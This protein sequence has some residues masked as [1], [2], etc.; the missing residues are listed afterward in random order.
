MSKT[1]GLNVIFPDERTAE[2]LQQAKSILQHS[3]DTSDEEME[4]SD[5]SKD[6]DYANLEKP[7]RELKIV[8][9]AMVKQEF[10]KSKFSIRTSVCMSKFIKSIS[11]SPQLRTSHFKTRSTGFKQYFSFSD[12]LCFCNNVPAL[13][14]ALGIDY[15]V[16]DWRLFIDTGKKSLKAVLLSN[17]SKHNSIPIAYSKTMPEKYAEMKFLMEKIQYLNNCWKVCC[18]LKMLAILLGLQTGNTK[19]SCFFCLWD[20]N[21][22]CDHYDK[23]L[24]WPER[25]SHHIGDYNAENPPLIKKENVLLPPLHLK[26]GYMTCF[27]KKLDSNLGEL[28]LLYMFNKHC[29]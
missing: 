16:K 20:R 19:F 4:V 6:P 25:N 7:V 21:A 9:P 10:K 5:V 8:T 28:F 15:N 2:E 1:T 23:T 29:L 22:A 26:L 14:C 17:H 13:V 11:N 3:P 18:D 27:I 12:G 24:Q